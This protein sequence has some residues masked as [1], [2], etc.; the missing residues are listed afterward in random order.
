[1]IRMVDRARQLY[2]TIT[3]TLFVDDMTAEQTGP[4]AHIQSDLGGFIEH[5]VEAMEANGMQL[6]R[7]KSVFTA[8]TDCLGALMEKR[9]AEIGLKY[10]RKVKALGAGMAG[11]RRR[12]V[13]TMTEMLIKFRKRLPRFRRLRR[14]GISTV[15]LLK[16]G[17]KAGMTYA[18]GILGVSNSML[19]CQRRAVAAVAAPAS[20]CGGQN[21]DAALLIAVGG[22]RS[23]VDPAYDAH[24]LSIGE[25]ATAEWE[26][27]EKEPSLNAMVNKAIRKQDSAKSPWATVCGPAGAMLAS[28]RRL[29][30]NVRDATNITT[31][32]GR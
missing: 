9:W 27:W 7:T 30:W 5:V 28:C 8:S 17:G 21:L 11:G 23:Q 18:E 15:R 24:T 16:T 10:Y 6:N 25:W 14:V 3:P 12:N 13:D 1:M 2:R 26:W 31:D 20:G 19:R 32:E 22:P 29:L 4:H